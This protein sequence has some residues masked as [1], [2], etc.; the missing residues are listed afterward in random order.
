MKVLPGPINMITN[1]FVTMFNLLLDTTIFGVPL[2]VW[3]IIPTL[4]GIFLN[5]IKE[6]K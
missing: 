6:K 3:F 5:F 4:I 2:L 1:L